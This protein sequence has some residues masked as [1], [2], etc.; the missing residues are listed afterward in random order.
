MALRPLPTFDS[1]SLTSRQPI[2][3]PST[4]TVRVGGLSAAG[5]KFLM[6]IPGVVGVGMAGTRVVVV[7][8][9]TGDAG[10]HVPATLE[11]FTLR[12]E[13]IGNVRA[14]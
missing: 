5:R 6:S 1:L 14:Y 13:V 12:C 8:L 7:Y 11:G 10:A 9:A 4:S 2:H 3:Q